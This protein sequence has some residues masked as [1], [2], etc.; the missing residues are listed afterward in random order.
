MRRRR[1]PLALALAL[2]LALGGC[3]RLGSGDDLHLVCE[4]KS[5]SPR[6]AYDI[7]FLVAQTRADGS[8]AEK[9][10]VAMLELARHHVIT[11]GGRPHDAFTATLAP[12]EN[13]SG[14]WRFEALGAIESFPPDVYRVWLWREGDAWIASA[15]RGEADV[16]APP[17]SV[18]QPAWDAANASAEVGAAL[19]NGSAPASA[20]WDPALPSCVHLRYAG[21]DDA[22]RLRVVVNVV[23]SRV[24]LLDRSS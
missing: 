10:R 16:V 12:A 4:E 21:T 18:A 13:A 24:V 22:E 8:I 6:K 19:P 5:A 17:R 2:A 14:E 20:R 23:Q 1:L 11:I 3:L 15:E 9:D 7:G